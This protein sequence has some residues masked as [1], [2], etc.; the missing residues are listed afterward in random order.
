MSKAW[1]ILTKRY[2]EDVR[3][4]SSE[5]I[6]LAVDELFDPNELN[7]LEHPDI[8]FS[9]GLDEGPMYVL[10]VA[11]SGL[12]SFEKWADSDFIKLLEKHQITNL[13]VERAKALF[14]QLAN[15]EFEIA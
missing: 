10:S 13:T 11:I 5:Q 6:A 14:N 9:Y 15:G 12:G 3:D 2:G 8:F 1:R 4:P 7:D